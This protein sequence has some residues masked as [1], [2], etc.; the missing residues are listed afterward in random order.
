MITKLTGIIADKQPPILIIDVNGVGYEVYA[1]MNTFYH[2]PEIGEKTSLLTQLIVREDA[3]TLYGFHD[4]QERALFRA[5]I[6]VNGVGPKLALTILSGINSNTFVQ[7][8]MSDDAGTLTRIPGIGKKTAER[9]II[10]CRDRLRD[11]TPQ[12]TNDTTK[13]FTQTSDDAV[14]A[15]VALGYKLKEAERS[16]KAVYDSNLSSEALIREALKAM[17]T[18][19]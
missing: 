16:V 18:T 13:A 14:S 11:W 12:L 15:L 2:L 6:K 4:Q 10:E 7:C 5:L 19:A 8:I 3:H 17:M 1:S 9:L